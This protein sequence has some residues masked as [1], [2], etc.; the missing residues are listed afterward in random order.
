[1]HKNYVT[2]HNIHLL[3][4]LFL[5]NQVKSQPFYREIAATGSSSL[6]HEFRQITTDAEI[7]TLKPL[8]CDMINAVEEGL[9]LR[10]NEHNHVETNTNDENVYKMTN[11]Y[12][13]D[14]AVDEYFGSIWWARD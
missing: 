14:T 5:P 1:M 8:A 7:Q 13:I 11:M 9:D 3:F 12:D 4:I 6:R 2:I 10:K